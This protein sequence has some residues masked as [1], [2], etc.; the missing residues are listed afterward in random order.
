MNKNFKRG[1]TT[2]LTSAMLISS[3]PSYA[4]APKFKDVPA[5]HWAYS[6]VENM[7]KLGYL[8]G[9]DDGTFKPGN[10]LTFM[11]SMSTLSRLTNP[12]AA[13]KNAAKSEYK[14]LL[15]QLKVEH[16]WARDALS[17][18]LYKDIVSKDEL[19]NANDKGLLNKNINKI[20]VS[21]FVARTMGLEE[22]AKSKTVVFLPYKDTELIEASQRKYVDVLLDAGVL[23]SKG[24]GDGKFNPKSTLT[25]QVMATMLSNASDYIKKNPIA[26][27]PDTSKPVET[28]IVKS[29]IKRIT[30]ELGR[31]YLVIE[32][33]SGNESGYLVEN[34]T[35]ITIDGKTSDSSSLAVGQDVELTI[36]KGTLDLVSVKATSIEEVVEGIVKYINSSTSKM[37]LEYM[38]G[39]KTL[40]K[41]FTIDKNAKIYLDDK[42]SYLSDIKTGDTVTIRTQNSIISDIEAKAKIQKIEGIV[43]EIV[44]IKDTKD[45]EYEIT[46]VDSKDISHK[47]K[48]D[49]KTYI[50]RNNKTVKV[51][52]LKVKDNAYIISEYGIAQD[53]DAKVVKREI[54]G[55]IVGINNRFNQNTL[56]T[57]RN[58][59]TNKEED[60]ELTSGAYIRIDNKPASALPSTPGYYVEIVLEGDEIVDI[61]ADSSS[62][63]TS[64][65]GKID[66]IDTKNNI[67]EITKDNI[68]FENDGFKREAT[69]YVSPTAIVT[70][71]GA[72]SKYGIHDL[73]KGDKIITAGTY[74]GANY[75][76]DT[77][78][79]R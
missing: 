47:F 66:Y 14:S 77:I 70:I 4:A 38:D 15:D 46:I 27:V 36:K 61:Y 74:Q 79:V 2:V 49:S 57:I 32:D 52:D 28:E 62:L 76:V 33:R 43:K 44:P 5:K 71:K 11:E 20:T 13:E 17:I 35:P 25:R 68:N 19:V 22:A 23:D 65:S 69:I 53:I 64:V 41:D 3:V 6:Y 54:K 55:Y 26:P 51:T 73:R 34:T 9:Y 67:I 39:N 75:V 72:V 12:T 63:D 21:V 59:E 7:A 56:V 18:A 37:T 50:Y 1:I 24:E 48:I 8:S 31:K 42:V 16:E 78:I 40:T 58:T 45:L 29:T 60:Y 30:D 10:N